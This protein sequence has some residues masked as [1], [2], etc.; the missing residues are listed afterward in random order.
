MSIES[1]VESRSNNSCEICGNTENTS[2][3]IVGPEVEL[4][5]KNAA[6]VCDKCKMSLEAKDFT[7]TNHWRCLSTSMWSEFPAVQVLAWR[8]LN[9][10]RSEAWAIDLSEQLYLE[11]EILVWAKE[12]QPTGDEV[13]IKDNN[14]TQLFAGDSVTLIKDLNV[15]GANFTA[16]RGTM[17]RNIS[18]TDDPKY[19]EGKI[20][21]SQIVIIADFVKKQ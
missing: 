7:D 10:L 15:K 18:L 12:G 20:N 9:N 17:V 11:D 3:Y 16:K 5:E 6:L 2:L 4:S 21:G 8:I 1:I 14:G 13:V 19:I